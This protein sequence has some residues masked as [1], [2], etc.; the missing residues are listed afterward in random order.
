MRVSRRH[1]FLPNKLMKLDPRGRPRH[2]KKRSRRPLC[3][4][5]T[6]ETAEAHKESWRTFLD[7]R[8]NASQLFLEGNLNTLR[9]FTN[10]KVQSLAAHEI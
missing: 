5:S 8:A 9:I 10:G 7:I 6:E 1:F 4:A 3:H 2:P